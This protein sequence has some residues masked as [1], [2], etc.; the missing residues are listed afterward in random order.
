MGVS[1][2]DPDARV[3]VVLW[4]GLRV[5]W[6]ERAVRNAGEPFDFDLLGPSSAG[7]QRMQLLRVPLVASLL[8]ACGAEPTAIS[9]ELA[10]DIISSLD[11]TLSVATTTF[12]DRDVVEGETVDVTVEYTDRNGV[13]HDIAPAQGTTDASGAFDATLEGFT[14]DGT[15][16]VTATIAGLDV[17]SSATF[18]VLDR[19]PPTVTITPPTSVTRGNDIRVEV[20]VTDEIG[21]SQVFFETDLNGNGNGRDRGT[22]IASGSTEATVTFE[23]QVNDGVAI[24]SMITLYALAADLSGNQAAAD[25]VTVTVTQ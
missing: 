5:V 17:Q 9:I 19:T 4:V 22:V 16:T 25:P 8:T 11:G 21:V 6:V 10:P 14:F 18:A 1:G 23:F 12:A 20:H 3:L 15:G 7:G 13:T 24:G 2:L